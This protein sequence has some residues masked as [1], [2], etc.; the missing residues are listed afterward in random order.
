MATRMYLGRE[1]FSAIDPG[2]LGSWGFNYRQRYKME[3]TKQNTGFTTYTITG[4]TTSASTLMRQFI[5]RPMDS[6]VTLTSADTW[7]FSCRYSESTLAANIYPK[8]YMSVVSQT[9]I[10]RGYSFTQIGGVE[11]GTSLASRYLSVTGLAGSYALQ[12]GDRLVLEVGWDKQA[13]GSANASISLGD[14]SATSDLAASDGDTDIQVPW[15]EY[16]GTLSFQA[17]GAAPTEGDNYQLTSY[18]SAVL[19]EWI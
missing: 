6:G 17:E 12:S 13:S 10:A 15:F 1:S 3:T 2:T 4:M 11:F 8:I 5:T 19:D 14:P 7:K 18:I 9:G 16:S